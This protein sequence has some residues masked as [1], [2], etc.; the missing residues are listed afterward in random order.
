MRAVWASHSSECCVARSVDTRAQAF[1]HSQFT[2]V[3]KS[4][5][6]RIRCVLL[7]FRIVTDARGRIRRNQFFGRHLER[8]EELLLKDKTEAL[9]FH[10]LHMPFELD[11]S[12]AMVKMNEILE[13]NHN[14]SDEVEMCIAAATA[15]HRTDE[16]GFGFGCNARSLGILSDNRSAH[17]VSLV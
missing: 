7:P 2:A 15:Q 8:Y 3:F 1:A 11:I 13:V 4:R 17:C 12:S 14:G 9:V 16:R 10:I 5:I 6:E